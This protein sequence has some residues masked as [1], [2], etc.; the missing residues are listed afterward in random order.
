MKTARILKDEPL[1][2][3]TPDW[4]ERSLLVEH[5]AYTYRLHHSGLE[6]KNVRFSSKRVLSAGWIDEAALKCYSARRPYQ[7]KF[8]THACATN[9]K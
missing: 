1:N 2:I 8:L 6:H 9:S 3:L 7:R 4:I 5:W